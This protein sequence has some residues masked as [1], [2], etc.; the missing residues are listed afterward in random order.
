[1]KCLIMMSKRRVLRRFN[2]LLSIIVD[3]FKE[4]DETY[5]ELTSFEWLRNFGFHVNVTKKLNELNVY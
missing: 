3:F 2:E 1:M 4:S 5:P